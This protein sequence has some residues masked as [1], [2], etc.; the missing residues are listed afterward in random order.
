MRKRSSKQGFSGMNV[1]QGIWK[2]GDFFFRLLD[3]IVLLAGGL[4]PS[5][6]PALADSNLVTVDAGSL[7]YT[8]FKPARRR[9][10]DSPECRFIIYFR[11]RSQFNCRCGRIPGWAKGAHNRPVES[12]IDQGQDRRTFLPQVRQ[13]GPRATHCSYALRQTRK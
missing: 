2:K 6:R 12:G 3:V 1:W 7:A 13:P 11:F 9:Q 10:N 5:P 8:M 4:V